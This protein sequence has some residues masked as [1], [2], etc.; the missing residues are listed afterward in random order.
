MKIVIT[1]YTYIRRNLFEV[2]EYYKKKDEL[3]FILPK[4]W[5]AKGGT[6]IFYPPIDTKLKI[7]KTTTLFWHSKYPI[8]KGLLKGFMP[9]LK[10][11]L[12]MLRF[13]GYKVL[14]TASEPNLLTTVINALL[15]KLFGYKHVFNFWDVVSSSEKTK[16][17]RKVYDKLVCASIR[18][19]DGAVCGNHKSA[20]ILKFYVRLCSRASARERG[21]FKIAVFPTS[22]LDEN[23]F[24]PNVEPTFRKELRLDGKL[25]YLFA[26]VFNKQKGVE[27][28]I[29]AFNQVQKEIHEAHLLL[30]GAGPCETSYKEQV[31]R[32]KLEDKVNIVNWIKHER[33]PEL[34]SSC[35]IFIYPSIK[36]QGS[37]EQFGYA[38]AEAMLTEKPV[39]ASDSGAINEL[40]I[41]DKNG[42]FAPEKDVLKLAESMLKLGQS[43]LLRHKFGAYGRKYVIDHF[44]HQIIADK[45]Y[46]FFKSL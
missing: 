4:K 2:W 44:S 42:Y 34:Y 21:N 16:L 8:V 1:G 6:Q 27:Y 23:K 24:K 40:V 9:F 43:E 33:M 30:V 37:E 45:F 10:F 19:S 20:E 26:G 7:F 12:M 22:G 13:K 35:D 3:F 29:E 18:L 25:V 11:K 17:K 15:A 46:D 28:L 41:P 36:Y 39:I 38:I 31:L 14:F 32:Y 5:K